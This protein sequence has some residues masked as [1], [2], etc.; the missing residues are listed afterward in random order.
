[1]TI[2]A[3]VYLDCAECGKT[4]DDNDDVICRFCYESGDNMPFELVERLQ[5]WFRGISIRDNVTIPAI[6]AFEIHQKIEI[7]IKKW[8]EK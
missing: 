7:L 4:I 8:S 1:M 3:E 2:E 6:E 5:Q